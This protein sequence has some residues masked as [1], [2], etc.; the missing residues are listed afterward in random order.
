[1]M[2][3]SRTGT[4]R[5]LAELDKHGWRLLVSARG[6]LRNEGFRYALDNGAWTA[7]QR[8]EPFDVA[9]FV[10]A[11]DMLGAGADFVVVPDK[12]GDADATRRMADEW[13][14]RLGG[15][16]LYI[17]VQDGMTAEDLPT[18]CAGVFVGGSTEWKLRTAPYWRAETTRRGMLCHVARVNTEKRIE[19][20]RS[21]GATSVDGSS[22][23]R[24]AVTTERLD[25]SRRRSVQLSMEGAL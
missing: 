21:F 2:Y 22:A 3:A 14:P 1:M 20:C 11:V 18:E 8:R 12:V 10:R 15:L 7:F 17:A 16:R 24:F 25:R 5:N 4:R 19:W 6:V 23:S 9:A 13:I